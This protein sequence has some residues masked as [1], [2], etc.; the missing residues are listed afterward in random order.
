MIHVP[1]QHDP[2]DTLVYNSLALIVEKFL[3]DVNYESTIGSN[4]S[5]TMLEK[6]TRSGN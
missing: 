3:S 4:L 5:S 1:N 6:Q 2:G